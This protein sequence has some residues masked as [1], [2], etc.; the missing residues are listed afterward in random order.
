MPITHI[1]DTAHWVAM[2]RAFE[3]ERADALFDDPYARRMAGDLGG[4]IVRE[5]PHGQ[6]MAWAVIV[7]T[8]V[9]D[10]MI[11]DCIE[12]G[13]TQVLNL[14]AGLDTRA[15]RLM[16][17]PTLRWLDVD[18][19]SMVAHRRACLKHHRARCDHAHIA[20]DVNDA[21]ELHQIICKARKGRPKGKAEGPTLVVSEGLLVY[22][23]ADQVSALAERLQEEGAARWWITD[24]VSPLLLA[25]VGAR[26]PSNEAAASAPFQFAPR[27]STSFFEALGWHETSFRSTL[28]EAV[29]LQ[30]SPPLAQWWG[31][32]VPPWWPGSRQNLR[33][34]SG[35]ALMEARSARAG[36]AL[37]AT[38]GRKTP[39][40]RANKS[41]S[42]WAR[43][44]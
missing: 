28:D 8:A 44:E 33:R 34:M 43:G 39:A 9:M 3:S 2:Y 27:D 12:K 7:R 6:S 25:M 32:F 19:P 40:M 17:P 35:V 29:R 13:C 1:S 31:A 10:E 26:W 20:A 4:S 36:S 30:R 14:G 22:L 21:A 38:T 15:F 41:S 23:Q 5:V 11:L 18:L 42:T 37:R 16:L 24:L